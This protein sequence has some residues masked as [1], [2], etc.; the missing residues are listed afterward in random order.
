MPKGKFVAQN[1][2]QVEFMHYSK[3]QQCILVDLLEQMEYNSVIPDPETGEILINIFGER[4]YPV[5]K[6]M[7]MLY[8][9]PKF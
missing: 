1:I 2:L 9:M 7:R 3:Q 8:W 4:G 6:F 5:R